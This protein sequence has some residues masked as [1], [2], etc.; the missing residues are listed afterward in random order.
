MAPV[1]L[2]LRASSRLQ[3]RV[4][5][6]GQH[7][8]MLDSIL[9][10]FDIVP[11]VD[12]ALMSHNQT[13]AGLT[14]QVVTKVSELLAADA[15]AMILVQGDT[16]TAM[17]SSLAAFY[18]RVSVGH[19]E[20]GLRTYN[21][22]SPYPEE[23]NRRIIGTVADV[24]FA[25]TVLARQRLLEEQVSDGDIV[26]TGNTGIDSFLQVIHRLR[27]SGETPSE[28]SFLDPDRRMILITGHRRESFGQAFRD[29]C[30][31]LR[32]LALE[33]PAFEFV[34]PVHLNPNVRAPVHDIL[35]GAALPNFHLTDPMEYVPFVALMSRA[36]LI[37]TDSGG[38]QEEAPSIG[39]P[40]LVT[41]DTTERP[42]GL[43][44]GLIQLVGTDPVKLKHAAREI[45][46]RPSE[47]SC[48]S[49]YNPYGDGSAAARIVA[50][51][52]A[53]LTDCP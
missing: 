38:I 20:A 14:A 46:R 41:R 28:L 43:E 19:V 8:Q 42:E 25:P 34:Y 33:F 7:R 1:V 53:T 49:F 39:T 4:C 52:E 3:S 15:P 35:G 30:L 18:N 5:V 22:Y 13:L 47:R 10:F 11:D 29:V 45:L 40:V 50:H 12:L 17:T 27:S 16:T 9:A 24:H 2:A 36:D 26:V 37:I 31:A 44:S 32:D 21:K 23:I 48:K 6:T 51:L